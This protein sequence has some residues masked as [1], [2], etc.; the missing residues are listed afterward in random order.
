MATPELQSPG[1]ETTSSSSTS[2]IPVY[3]DGTAIEWNGNPAHLFGILHDTDKF[4][5][6]TGHF[7][8]YIRQ[9]AVVTT[10][11]KTIVS[12]VKDI[13]FVQGL[14]TDP[15]DVRN[16]NLTN[17][18]PPTAKRIAEYDADAASL[19]AGSGSS[20]PT[21]ADT[22]NIK[23]SLT[24]IAASHP[25][26]YPINEFMVER[27][28]KRLYASLIR[29]VKDPASLRRLT[30]A[31]EGDVDKL[32]SEL[33]RIRDTAEPGDIAVATGERD[34]HVSKGIPGEITYDS[35]DSFW[36]TYV[37]LERMKH[38]NSR[39]T[40]STSIQMINALILN[41]PSLR[42]IF[43]IKLETH[44]AKAAAVTHSDPATQ[45]QLRLDFHVDLVLAILRTRRTY[46]QLDETVHHRALVA[47]ADPQRE[48][49]GR[50]PRATRANRTANG[51]KR[52]GGGGGGGGDKPP[53]E[54]KKL[55]VPRDAD[56]RVIRWV[57]GMSLCPCGVDGG[58]HLFRD[59][60]ND[61]QPPTGAAGQ[62]SLAV[63][64]CSQCET[65]EANDVSLL[66]QPEIAASIAAWFGEQQPVESV[67]PGGPRHTSLVS[68]PLDRDDPDSYVESDLKAF[69]P[70][71]QTGVYSF[72][73]SYT[74]IDRPLFWSVGVGPH[75]G[76]F[77]GAW[78]D[79]APY[80][81]RHSAPP[82]RVTVKRF[83]AETD[84]LAHA[85]SNGFP[86]K[87]YQTIDPA[88][89]D[90]VPVGALATSKPVPAATA[91]PQPAPA[92]KPPAPEPK[93]APAEPPI[94]ATLSAGGVDP[95]V[96]A[97]IASLERIMFGLGAV[98]VVLIAA[99]VTA[100]ALGGVTP[101]PASPPSLEHSPLGRIQSTLD[102][103]DPRDGRRDLQRAL[104][105]TTAGDRA[106]PSPPAD[107]HGG[108]TAVHGPP[109]VRPL[110]RNL[111]L[112]RVEL[113]RRHRP[114]DRPV[115]VDHPRRRVALLLLA[116]EDRRR[117]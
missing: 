84:A 108:P 7:Q 51:D 109:G 14:A 28:G 78:S 64:Q 88:P 98:I 23:A 38:P 42:D 50:P 37:H 8:P 85:R 112:P 70:G 77:Y 9:R 96:T 59:C 4:Y 12:S 36:E 27:E 99:L 11:G 79:I 73:Q 19:T 1:D 95:A 10:G 31:C 68:A 86:L 83:A 60:K 65:D 46:K 69:P 61:G 89:S 102:S 66:D 22:P 94:P 30:T 52:S 115:L 5:K 117:P 107:S 76:V 29:I 113:A 15:V 75:P 92:P 45:D 41:D 103:G 106:H 24:A 47:A 26:E 40:G 114:R 111:R 104:A 25:A 2:I 80:V 18:C 44:A 16:R 93:P 55:V 82:G 58:T 53:K 32:V 110:A 35:F 105:A 67:P 21:F 81:H 63:E 71:E 17:L 34:A 3:P 13:P 48:G 49:G 39:A 100:I 90:F 101:P 56:N 91:A 74:E 20:A 62:K 97:K 54:E 33:V 87:S 57:P 6:R 43:E 116:G 72:D